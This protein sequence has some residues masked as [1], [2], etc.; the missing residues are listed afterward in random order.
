MCYICI[1]YFDEKSAVLF[2]ICCWVG[3]IGGGWWMDGLMG[4]GWVR[5]EVNG[6]CRWVTRVSENVKDGRVRDM[7][8]FSRTI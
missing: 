4:Y 8:S 6:S 3:F 7:S 2:Y 1:E 5:P